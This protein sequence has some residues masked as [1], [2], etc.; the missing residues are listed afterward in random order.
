MLR[1]PCLTLSAV[2]AALPSLMVAQEVPKAQP[3]QDVPPPFTLVP[4]AEPVDPGVPP[5]LEIRKAT[6]TE[7]LPPGAIP[8]T[9]AQAPAP[10]PPPPPVPKKK[11]RTTDPVLAPAPPPPPAPEL[12]AGWQTQK[13]ART[14][15]LSVPAPRGQIVDRHG[16]PFAQSRSAQ[17]LALNFPYLGENATD[18]QILEYAAARVSAANRALHKKW[19]LPQD[20]V[21]QHYKNRRWL[22]LVF[23]ISEGINDELSAEQQAAIKP[24]MT[25]PGSG[26]LLQP[27]Y[28]RVYPKNACAAH[29]LGYT[30]KTRPLPVGPIQDGDPLFE[31]AE[32]REGLEK[33]FDR[34]LQ[35]KAGLVNVLF[36]PD[37]TK[38]KE[39]V[40]RRP[41]PGNNVVTTL[42]YNF[43]K[44][45]ENALAKH[46]TGGA[47]VILD[48]HTG[49]VLAM[50]SF[51]L[52]DPNEWIPG[53]TKEALQRLNQDKTLPLFA[54]AF[55]GEYP[56]AST[57][58]VVVSLAGLESGAITPRT[59]F[60]CTSSLVVGDHVFKNWNKEG[61]G[62]LNV[63]GAIKRSCNTWFYQ[64]GNA[65][66]A[67]PITAMAMRLG[68]GER[69]GIPL[70]ERAGFVPTDAWAM[71][72]WGHKMLGGDIANLS[73]GQGTTLV[74]PLQAAQ[75]MAAVASSTDMPQVRLVQQV[76]DLND[77]VVKAFAP[78]VR[79]QVNL[80]PIAHDT[81][82]KGMIAVVSGE[83]GTGQAAGLPQCQLAGKTGTAQWKPNEKRNLAW[84]TGFLPANDPLYAFAVIYEGQPGEE[85]SG[86]HKAAPIVHEVFEN[87]F[88]N[89]PPDEPLLLLTQ[90]KENKKGIALNR[91]D[92]ETDGGAPSTNEEESEQ[93]PQRPVTQVARDDNK[94]G[95]GGFFK[96]LFGGH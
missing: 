7:T 37:G 60:D 79:R 75:A 67:S 70:V 73:I 23:S 27:A 39:E 40:L 48:V 29:I 3:V 83:N 90:N 25:R 62:E 5:D 53:I 31:E 45:A 82:L 34:E 71:Q 86:G 50:A 14:F 9:P 41:I 49:D 72:H 64:A 4:K 58:K 16:V 89:S 80:K 74:T 20:R 33:S 76:Q 8:R 68:F 51:P 44:Y 54:R 84:F 2:L 43:Q 78:K 22:P 88:K 21:I 56:P 28:L 36:N 57:F 30:G 10:T 85:I 26:L 6:T 87:I 12:K 19:N 55:Q 52:Y 18:A 11:V 96:R 77:R 61:E 15:T 92:E 94:K 81:V 59:A 63:V 35:G 46:T 93:R 65:I 66:G 47:M 69:T 24:L 17:Y 32:G 38:V 42:D 13:E 95:I 1:F 91:Q